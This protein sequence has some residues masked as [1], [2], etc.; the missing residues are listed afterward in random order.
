MNFNPRNITSI[1]MFGVPIRQT[2]FDI[3]FMN[4]LLTDLKFDHIVEL[5]TYQGGLTVFL[6]LHALNKGIDVTTFDVRIEPQS[7][8]YN[9]WKKLLPIT[10][11]QLNVFSEE[12]KRIVREKAKTGRMLIML[13]G[14]DKPLDF[15]TYAPLLEANDVMLIHDKDR[16]IFQNDVNP[17]A[18]ANGL[19]PFYQDEINK[20]GSDIFCFIK[21]RATSAKH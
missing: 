12:A 20:I 14:G 5:G 19:E 3:F 4:E 16:Y 2:C 8:S 18:K 11:Y 10:F 21:K 6:G 9:L 17:I 1:H 13:D 15:K 7:D